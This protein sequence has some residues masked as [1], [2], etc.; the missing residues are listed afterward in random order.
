M[1]EALNK[2]GS[3]LCPPSGDPLQLTR[4]GLDKKQLF[5]VRS[6]YLHLP[7]N[8]DDAH[9][10]AVVYILSLPTNYMLLIQCNVLPDLT[11]AR[12][13]IFQSHIIL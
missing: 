13:Y 4:L 11:V 6:M 10:Y 3:F 1:A 12:A 7:L 8:R 2:Q 5:V 9:N